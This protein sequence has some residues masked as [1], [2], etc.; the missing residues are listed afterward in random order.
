M[1]SLIHQALNMGGGR[2]KGNLNMMMGQNRPV[3][4]TNKNLHNIFSNVKKSGG[5]FNLHS[6]HNS[7][8]LKYV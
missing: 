6:N 5:H 2:N 3:K 7:G 4:P 1:E 8:L